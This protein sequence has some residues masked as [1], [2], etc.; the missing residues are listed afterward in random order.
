MSKR[1]VIAVDV[2]DVLAANAEGFVE[3]SNQRWGTKLHPSDYHDHW[4]E[5]WGV[6]RHVAIE[7]A[8]IFANEAQFMQYRHFDEAVD[9]LK[10][11]SKIYKLII[12]TARRISAE[13]D[14]RDWINM[15]FKDIFSEI[16]FAGIWDATND[17]SHQVGKGAFVETVGADYLIDDQ[18]KH[19]ISSSERGIKSLLFGDYTW[20]N[21]E[22]LPKNVTRVHDW[23][24]IRT[25]FYAEK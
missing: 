12:V 7:R 17:Y 16:H 20:N 15:Y 4:A 2:D 3:F 22:S 8:D 19:C 25:Y 14:T 10:E 21:I 24:D 11:L 18:I 5:L 23:C 9:V 6:E 1:K 13:K